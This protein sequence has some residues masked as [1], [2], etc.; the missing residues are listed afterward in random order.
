MDVTY[1][2]PLLSLVTLLAVCILALVSK[3][4][5]DAM[6]RDPTTPTSTLAKVGPEGGVT[7]N[8]P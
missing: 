7:F 8:R 4:R 1:L 3:A 2:I 5:V 6:R